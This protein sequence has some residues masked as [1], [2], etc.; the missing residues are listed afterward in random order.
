M[1]LNISVEFSF[2]ESFFAPYKEYTTYNVSKLIA[3][4]M[5]LPCN[6]N[7]CYAQSTS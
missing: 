1:C 2:L 5:D 6:N 3:I 7:K 4:T